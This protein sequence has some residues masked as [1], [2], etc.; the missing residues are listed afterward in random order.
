MTPRITSQR[1]NISYIPACT[2]AEDRQ[3]ERDTIF[4]YIYI[5]VRAFSNILLCLLT[6]PGTAHLLQQ[7]GG[8][9]FI[10]IFLFFFFMC[11]NSSGLG[12]RQSQCTKSSE[13]RQQRPFS[14]CAGW[15]KRWNSLVGAT[16]NTQFLDFCSFHGNE[17]DRAHLRH[18]AW[19]LCVQS[20]ESYRRRY[21]ITFGFY[22]CDG[23]TSKEIGP[24]SASELS[25]ASSRRSKCVFRAARCPG[26]TSK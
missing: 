2:R 22:E 15:K 9:V 5:T 7:Q 21:L 11:R 26:S 12:G 4:F 8:L 1:T 25:S 24:P 16:F 13:R 10:S 6:N 23:W 14:C 18:Q 17:K 19:C 3:T 20:Q